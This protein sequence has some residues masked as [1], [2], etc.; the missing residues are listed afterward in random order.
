MD[1]TQDLCGSLIKWLQT[2]E[3]EAHHRTAEDI[4]DGVAMAQALAQIA[5]EWFNEAFT[6]K[7][8]A[9]VISNWRLKASNLK[10]IVEAIVDY[11]QECLN[12]HLVDFKKPDINQIAEKCNR[13][14]LGRLLQLILGC[15]VNCSHKQ[16]YITIIMGMEESVQQVIMQS[17]Q[18]LESGGVTVISDES[19]LQKL[20]LD[21][22]KAIEERNQ[23]EQRC[24]ELDMQ[25]SLL[26]EE[27]AN[28]LQEN[29]KL[30][31]RLQEV[32]NPLSA[33]L[34]AGNKYSTLKKEFDTLKEEMFRVET[35]RDDLLLKSEAQERDLLEL[36]AKVEELQIHADEARHL[37]DEIDVL[38]ETADKVGKYEATIESYKRKLEELSDLKRQLKILEEKN[39]SYMQHNLELEDEVKKNGTWK[40]QVEVYKKQVAELHQKL[41]D[42][43]K[44][45]DKFDFEVKKAQEKIL[46]LTRE[47]EHL[48]VERDC[49]KETN[50]ELRCTQLS[51]MPAGGSLA[52]H[53]EPGPKEIGIEEML[54]PE[55][56]QKLTRL[57]MENKMLKLKQEGS[58]NEQLSVVKALL[59]DANKEVQK[60]TSE[61]RLANQRILK[62]ESQMEE[63]QTERMSECDN[64][65]FALRKELMAVHAQ[66]RTLAA[67]NESQ[68]QKLEQQ[69]ENLVEAN[70]KCIHL[71][72]SLARKEAEIQDLEE[73]YKKCVEKAKTV[74]T[75]IDSKQ[76][77]ELT[78]LKN[79][80]LEKTNLIQRLEKN[81]EVKNMHLNEE[82]KFL[83]T[84]FWR[85]GSQR[86]RES[87]DQR[88]AA[89]SSGQS[90][91]AR[92]RQPTNRR[93]PN[94]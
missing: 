81:E 57:T 21:V 35:M 66:N 85:L 92:Q 22:N 5:P 86:Q 1:K 14:E 65:T 16:D 46:A 60:L 63:M 32:D 79:Q 80:L 41:S 62:L 59:E 12:Q 84:N 70:R 40:P 25:V 50:E 74:L 93:L 73:R 45:A 34:V 4:S 6:S 88:L 37:K 54:P 61:N 33:S 76:N 28:I 8:K 23:M 90:F 94:K 38:K 43:T 17:I 26:Q 78:A 19:H 68:K 11:Y 82:F 44:R 18:E 29:K 69:E 53:Q 3:L 75:S 48:T 67:E 10:K 7:I 56:K 83:I 9:D 15:A 24:H 2:F 49:L 27:K 91:L 42:E 58:G 72:D 39:T 71:K 64:D 52:V 47:K 51:A 30:Q 87:V 13:E 31:E 20:I 36:Q 89:L 77:V 55:V